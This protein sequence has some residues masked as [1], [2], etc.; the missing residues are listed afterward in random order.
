VRREA[1]RLS[2]NINDE[3]VRSEVKETILKALN[4]SD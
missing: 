2:E 3:E 1:V 4:D